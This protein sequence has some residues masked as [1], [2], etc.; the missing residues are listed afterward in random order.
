VKEFEQEKDEE[1]YQI[2]S[3]QLSDSYYA[4]ITNILVFLLISS[5]SM[6]CLL[7][8]LNE[9]LKTA[10]RSRTY[11]STSLSYSISRRQITAEVSKIL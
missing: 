5:S 8:R 2:S 6:S 3:R 4:V 9:F 11:L 10:N 7:I 1:K